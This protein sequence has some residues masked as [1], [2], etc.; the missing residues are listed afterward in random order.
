MFSVLLSEKITFFKKAQIRQGPSE[1]ACRDVD[2]NKENA[3]AGVCQD[4]PDLDLTARL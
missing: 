4:R 1:R 2:L 3:R